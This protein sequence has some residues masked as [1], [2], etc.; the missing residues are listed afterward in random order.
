MSTS[1]TISLSELLSGADA[2]GH[3]HALTEKNSGLQHIHNHATGAIVWF[4]TWR[5]FRETTD[6]REEVDAFAEDLK[7]GSQLVEK[8]ASRSV[9]GELES[10][11]KRAAAASDANIFVQDNLTRHLTRTWAIADAVAEVTGKDLPGGGTIPS[12]FADYPYDVYAQDGGAFATAL[13]NDVID[14]RRNRALADEAARKAL[15]PVSRKALKNAA[16]KA[17]RR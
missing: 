6:W 14:A 5:K 4:P 3:D 10:L 7:S 13:W 11:L 17:A 9:A 12:I 16:R 8:V 2:V 15:K 1:P